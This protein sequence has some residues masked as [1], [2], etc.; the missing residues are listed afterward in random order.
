MPTRINVG[1]C[2]VDL[3][4]NPAKVRML[5]NMHYKR[6]L[7]TG[8]PNEVLPGKPSRKQVGCKFENCK[9]PHNAKGYCYTHYFRW[10][11]YNDPSKTVEK[12]RYKTR[13]GYIKKWLVEE[14][15][16]VIEHRYIM[17]QHLGRKL[18]DNENVHH[19]NGV[20]DDNRIENLELWTTS[21]PSG[22]RVEDKIDWA[23][24][25]LKQYAPDKLKEEE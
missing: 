15:R 19:K 10:K 23:V 5:C 14:K 2:C 17:E 22:Q 6:W 9:N 21:Q 18:T 13:F 11:R 12:H 25:I 7:K 1:S 8:N 16:Y 4:D 20:R 24:E 3:C